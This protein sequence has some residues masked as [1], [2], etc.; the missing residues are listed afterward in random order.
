MNQERISKWEKNLWI[1]NLCH[2]KPQ[3]YNNATN[4][5]KYP[6]KSAYNPSAE[7]N[8]II[9]SKPH[10]IFLGLFPAKKLWV[11]RLTHEDI[12]RFCYL[13]G[14]LPSSLTKH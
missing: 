7:H 8:I 9:E 5:K 4:P 14:M 2:I 12:H 1:V 3:E 11:L 10:T 13:G 6:E